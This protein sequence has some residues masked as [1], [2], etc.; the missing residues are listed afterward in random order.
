MQL[1]HY[2]II[3]ILKSIKPQKVHNEN[4]YM[5]IARNFPVKKSTLREVL[6]LTSLIKQVLL[7]VSNVFLLINRV[8]EFSL[9]IL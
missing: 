2:T 9:L 1:T 6:R 4:G 3:Q 5:C 7:I 8:E